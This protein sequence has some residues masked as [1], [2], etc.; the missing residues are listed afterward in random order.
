MEQDQFV[1]RPVNDNDLDWLFA[2]AAGA[3]P[4]LTSWPNNKEFVAK[5]IELVQQSIKQTID[6]AQRL[7]LFVRENIATKERVGVC[8]IHANVGFHSLFY[9][10]QVS[11]VVQA[12]TE[13]NLVVEHKIINLV[14]NFQDASE[15]ISF[16]I[17]PQFRGKNVARSLSLSRFIYMA[18]FPTW[19]GNQVIA[20]VRGV[21]NDA[22]ISP[23]WE[24]VGR[25]FFAMDFVRADALT[26]LHGKQY[27]ADLI[28]R[29]PIYLDLLAKEAQS[30]VG[31]AHPSSQNARHILEDAGLQYNNHIDIFD[32]GPL[33]NAELINVKT[34]RSSRL[35]KIAK[36]NNK[37]DQGQDAIIFNTQADARITVGKIATTDNGE[38]IINDQLAKILQV[39]TSDQVR[40]VL[41]GND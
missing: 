25:H 15:L 18:Q 32:A 21:C 35:C 10:Y 4:G 24:A 19:F 27:I 14:N 38:V 28:A 29:E 34:V 13:L 31:K 11:T 30:V 41:L 7:F 8:G 36:I 26:L 1:I 22:G 33:L 17:H 37:L 3:G 12:C 6:P 16:W 20:E 39:E 23:F 9:N 5:R 2:I 40:F